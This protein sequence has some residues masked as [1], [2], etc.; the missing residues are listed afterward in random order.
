VEGTV[1]AIR[2]LTDTGSLGAGSALVVQVGTNSALSAAD[3]ESILDSVPAETLVL[4]M[5]VHAPVDWV[6]GNNELIR[7]VLSKAGT[8]ARVVDWDVTAVDEELCPDGIHV[9]CNPR[10]ADRYVGLV[11]SSIAQ[12]RAES[13]LLEIPAEPVKRYVVRLAD[14]DWLGAAQLLA[15]GGLEPEARADLRPLFAPEFGLVP[16]SVTTETLAAALERWCA[17]ALCLSPVD[18]Q[19]VDG[20]NRAAVTYDV[21][22]VR[23]TSMFVGGSFEGRPTVEGLPLQL[24][25]GADL[26]ATVECPTDVVMRTS[27]AD[28]DGDGWWE[29]I[30]VQSFDVEGSEMGGGRNVVTVC[31]TDVKVQPLELIDGE[32][33]WVYAVNP[34]RE[35]PDDLL[36]GSVP[37]FPAGSIYQYVDVDGVLADTGA[38]F[39]FIGLTGSPGDS[40]GC[41]DLDSNGAQE[42]VRYRYEFIGG[43]DVS[44]S[45]ALQ[46]DV[47]RVFGEATPNRITIDFPNDPGSVANAA[48]VVAGYCHGLPIRT[49]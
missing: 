27:W 42:L 40:M 18:L 38:T 19:V 8:L 22:G 29:Q 21:G 6:A 13:T 10:A 16:G 15:E 14:G 43:T 17:Q 20:F 34:D 4:F 26:A 32:G 3:L 9:S 1:D 30:V 39:G 44:N 47:S 24:P 45:V 48:E 7:T 5:T 49:N 37:P 46:Y 35:G 28:V 41:E 23:R 2:T 33:I 11:M 36:I 25:T 12:A 31:G